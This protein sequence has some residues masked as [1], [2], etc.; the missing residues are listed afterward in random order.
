MDQESMAAAD[1]QGDCGLKIL[2]I[3]PGNRG[4]GIGLLLNPGRVEMAFMVVDCEKGFLQDEGH[5]LCRFE[6]DQEGTG[7]TRAAGGGDGIK[8]ARGGVSLFE[9]LTGDNGEILE[10][11]AGG[12]LRDHAAILGV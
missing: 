1:D 2:H 8:L 7:Q 5:G 9:G 3:Q 11:F 6:A 10:M 12:K 4:D